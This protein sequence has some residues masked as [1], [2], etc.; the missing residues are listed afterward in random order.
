MK[1]SL[2]HISFRPAWTITER[3]SNLLGQC[4]AYILT[5]TNTPIRPDYRK[6]LLEVS[7]RRGALA[8]T[9]IEGNTLS[10]KDMDRIEA[11]NDLPPSRQYLQREVRNI[12]EALNLLRGELVEEKKPSLIS[13][14]LIQ[15]FHKL[16]GKG[17]GDGYGNPGHFRRKNVTVGNYRPPP[18]E[19]VEKLV[20]KFCDWV[21]RE[22][23]YTGGQNFD[24]AL[25]QAIVSHVYI[26][27]IHPFLDGNGRTARLM[28]FYLL[29]RAGVP[30]IASHLLS[31]HYNNTRGIYY[32]QLRNAAEKGTLTDFI[33][34]ALEGFRD[35]LEHDILK[36][37]HDDQIDM[38]WK[39]Y[40][41]DITGELRRTE[42]KNEKIIQRV[43]QL[44]Y[45]LPSDGF[46]AVDQ[47]KNADIHISRAYEGLTRPTLKSD[48]TLL[49]KHHLLMEENGKY[50][51][52]KET[53]RAFMPGTSAGITKHY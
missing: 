5:I 7:L 25:L 32:Q 49:V 26:A 47:I 10:E 11:G 21:S 14:R 30:D 40:V 36:V 8:T 38:T 42:G 41:H 52:N 12:I 15:Q 16:V 27:W 6:K 33:L 39:N 46:L 23:H 37:I 9:A 13:V 28:E 24:E 50:R 1:N 2:E 20:K 3:M 35:G 45:Y 17:L 29:L 4:Y 53:L 18:F 34:Y 19:Q 22:F 48:L 44:A 51:S 31:N 43:R